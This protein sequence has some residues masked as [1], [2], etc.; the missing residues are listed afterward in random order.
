[1]NTPSPRISRRPSFSLVW[2]VPV[3]ALGIAGWMLWGELRNRGPQIT[4]EFADGSGLEAGKTTL[5]HKGVSVGTVKSVELKKDLS[6]VIVRLRLDKDA[7]ALARLGSQFWIVHPEIGFSGVR[8]LETLVTGVRLNVLPGNGPPAKQFRG[9]DKP[10]PPDNVSLG[11]A[12]ILQSD[13]LGP[14]KSGAPVNY[15][16]IRVGSVETSRLADDSASVLIRIRIFTPYISLVRA[17]SRFWS[18]GGLPIKISLFGSEMRN[19]SFESLFTGAVAFATPE[20]DATGKL[21]PVPDEDA[22]FPLAAEPDKEWLKWQP[23]I[24]IQA[25]EESPQAPKRTNLPSGLSD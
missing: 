21:A 15:R 23:I 14:I 3:V 1:M 9:L 2:I 7:A 5:E 17:N 18:V 20:A 6:G 4:I 13:R 12:F 16:D 22:M 11:R 24:P 19:I 10:P 25:P 8:G